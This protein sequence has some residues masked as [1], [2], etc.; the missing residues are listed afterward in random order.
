[1]KTEEEAAGLV[2]RINT[3]MTFAAISRVIS[4]STNIRG[5]DGEHGGVWYVVPVGT[6]YFVHLRFEHPQ[7]RK[8]P[9][10]KTGIMDCLLNY[11]PRL[12]VKESGL[13][14]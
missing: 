4:L 11:P 9:L 3:N 13:E 7:G 6:N 2:S 1:M 10:G 8:N 14:F 12:E 5:F